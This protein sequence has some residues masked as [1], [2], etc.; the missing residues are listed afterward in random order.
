MVVW[1]VLDLLV[2]RLDKNKLYMWL[3]EMTFCGN[4]II[5]D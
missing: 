2:Y 4:V 3:T 5:D 1:H